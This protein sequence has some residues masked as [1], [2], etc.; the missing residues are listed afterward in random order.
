MIFSAIYQ[1]LLVSSSGHFGIALPSLHGVAVRLTLLI[2]MWATS[3]RLKPLEPLGDLPHSPF[4]FAK[5]INSVPN[6][7]F[8][9]SQNLEWEQYRED[10]ADPQRTCSTSG[11]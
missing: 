3:S 10:L 4:S 1:F 9:I 8:L 2:E 6:G 11:K 5:M 7:D